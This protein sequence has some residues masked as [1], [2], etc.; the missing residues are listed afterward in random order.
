MLYHQSLAEQNNVKQIE[1]KDGNELKELVRQIK[2]K[3]LEL[4][5][6]QHPASGVI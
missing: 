2:N 4:Q 6:P 3:N 5:Q 1:K